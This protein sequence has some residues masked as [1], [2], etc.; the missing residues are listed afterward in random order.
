MVFFC[1]FSHCHVFIFYIFF[2][3][4]FNCALLTQIKVK[5]LFSRLNKKITVHMPSTFCLSSQFHGFSLHM[6]FKDG[7][8]V[9]GLFLEGAGWDKK[10]SCLVEA[11]PMQMYCPVPTIHFKPVEN[12]KKMGK[13]EMFFIWHE[14]YVQPVDWHVTKFIAR[15][16][17]PNILNDCINCEYWWLRTIIWQLIMIN[18]Y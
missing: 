4:I 17:R 18:C 8:F 10:N 16:F 3:L 1:I 15:N 2:C 14:L 12:R 5:N 11:E 7:V 6:L 9:R 13:G